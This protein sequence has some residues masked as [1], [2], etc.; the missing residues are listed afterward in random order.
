LGG[1][2]SDVLTALDKT[3]DE[4]LDKSIITSNH[5]WIICGLL[6]WLA[7]HDNRLKAACAQ[8]GLI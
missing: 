8:R 3:V 5:W 4:R 7:N 6:T 1:P 2:S